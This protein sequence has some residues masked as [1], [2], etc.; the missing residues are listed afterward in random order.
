[1][2]LRRFVVQP[3]EAGAPLLAFL[4]EQ[5][6]LSNRQAKALLDARKVFVNGQRVWMARHRISP[7]DRVEIQEVVPACPAVTAQSVLFESP[8]Y[9]IANKPPG[10]LA[11]V[12]PPQAAPP[13]TKGPNSMEESLRRELHNPA[14]L[15][16]H[17]LDRD[18]SGCLLF[19]KSAE[20]LAL[21]RPLFVK[22]QIRKLYQA[23]VCGCL[24][25]QAREITC[26]I[27]GQSARTCV[28]TLRTNKWASHLQIELE[29]GRTH[30]IRRH[31]LAIGH[32]VLGD[33]QYGTKRALSPRE[34]AVPRQMLHAAELSFYHPVTGQLIRAR[35]PLPDDFKA[36]LRQFGLI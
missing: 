15:A 1:M 29:T 8:D 11:N 26:R 25:A 4:A 21:V 19:A 23:I 27:D 33:Q 13:A 10:I 28:K 12:Y 22:R 2:T 18:T 6:Q 7:R 5:M 30:Q 3:A 31:L 14:L 9:L 24:G 34:L 20:A 17:R 36:C 16:V 35:S 32:P